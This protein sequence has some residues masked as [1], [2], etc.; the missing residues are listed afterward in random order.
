MNEPAEQP[1]SSESFFRQFS[2]SDRKIF[3]YILAL[4]LDVAAAEDIYQ[5]TCV[6]LWKEFPQ[7]DPE[8]SF[9]NWA[10]GIAF[11]QIRKYRRKFQNQRLIFSDTLVTALAEDVS[12]MVEEQSERQLA[13]T[14][15]LENLSARERNLL[16][17][18]YGDQQ[19][20]AALAE[21]GNC[22]VHAI[23]KTIKKLR[24]ALHECVTRRLANEA[25]S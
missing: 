25:S 20:A 7:Y 24:R 16:D 15:C 22:S 13:L 1:E 6:I 19:T 5:E 12:S 21:Q 3:G 4:V 17:S 10:Y 23:Y 14:C 9:L 2:K 18:Y 11:N 8:R